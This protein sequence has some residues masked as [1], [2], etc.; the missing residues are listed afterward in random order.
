MFPC[1]SLVSVLSGDF[2]CQ[3]MIYSGQVRLI[4]LQMIS[5]EPVQ[6]ILYEKGQLTHSSQLQSVEEASQ[7]DAKFFDSPDGYQTGSFGMQNRMKSR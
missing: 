4:P 7:L 1:A 5:L 2:T 3:L 6:V